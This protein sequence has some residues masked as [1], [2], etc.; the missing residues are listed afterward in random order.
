MLSPD[1]QPP[2]RIQLPG[3]ATPGRTDRAK[4]LQAVTVRQAV[5]TAREEQPVLRRD[6]RDPAGR[7]RVF[8][9]SQAGDDNGGIISSARDPD[10]KIITE[11]KVESDNPAKLR[12]PLVGIHL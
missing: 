12:R 6:T 2:A 3:M 8:L 9:S 7:G 1:L 10:C 5:P 4:T 11:D